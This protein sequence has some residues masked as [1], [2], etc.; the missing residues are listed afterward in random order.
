MDIK[1]ER[2]E[3]ACHLGEGGNLVII[4]N[5][6]ECPEAKPRY[7]NVPRVLFL[8]VNVAR[9]LL[10][11]KA[12]LRDTNSISSYYFLFFKNNK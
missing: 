9:I 6:N 11:A 10:M 8:L 4:P 3:G 12:K 2:G 5:G 7:S 1:C